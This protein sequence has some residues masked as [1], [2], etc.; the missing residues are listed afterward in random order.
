M[1]TRPGCR[2]HAI[3]CTEFYVN[4]DDVTSGPCL[5]DY[6][7]QALYVVELPPTKEAYQRDSLRRDGTECVYIQKAF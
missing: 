4:N 1:E 3:L 2:V 6:A 5:T 7:I